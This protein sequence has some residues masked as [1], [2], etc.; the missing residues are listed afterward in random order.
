MSEIPDLASLTH[1]QTDELILAL[2]QRVAPLQARVSESVQLLSDLC[3]V[4][5]STATIQASIT[6]AGAVLGPRVAQIAAAVRAAPVAHFDETGQRVG[7]RL[8]WMHSASTDTLTWYGSHA[9]RGQEA[10]GRFRDPPRLRG[11]RSP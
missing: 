8:H 7:G 5:L 3:R 11:H 9:K 2:Y 1:E 10:I 6:Q 4:K